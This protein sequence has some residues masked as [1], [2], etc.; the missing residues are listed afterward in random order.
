MPARRATGR[1]RA[2]VTGT[3]SARPLNTQPAAG[4]P[5]AWGVRRGAVGRIRNDRR[6]AEE[7]RAKG[8]VGGERTN[9]SAVVC[10][11]AEGVA[12]SAPR[13]KEA[14]APWPVPS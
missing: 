8:K 6:G 12:V 10:G 5:A 3:S 13:G 4:W 1:A 9:A 11:C 14:R 2:T 7:A